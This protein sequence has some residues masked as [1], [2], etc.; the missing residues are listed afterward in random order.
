MSDYHTPSN[1][2]NLTD[3][4]LKEFFKKMIEI[5]LFEDEGVRLYKQG[6]VGGFYHSYKGQE[7][8]AVA[9]AFV[10]GQKTGDFLQTYRCHGLYLALNGSPQAGFAELLGKREGCSG[11][12]GGS[13][14]LSLPNMPLGEGIVCGHAALAA[15]MAHAK[16]HLGNKSPQVV[17]FLGDGAVAQGLIYEA[18]N[19]AKLSKA[20][21]IY[22]I[23][24]N[25][26][27]MG[28]AV[29]RAI[30]FHP[31]GKKLAQLYDLSSYYLKGCDLFHLID[32]FTD[33]LNDSRKT[34]MPIIVEVD[35]YRYQGH[36]ISDPGNYR[37]REEI[38]CYIKKN[39]CIAIIRKEMEQRKI[40]I[41]TC[42]KEVRETIRIALDK[43]ME[44]KD[45][46]EF[47]MKKGVLDEV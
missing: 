35:T 6:A 41:E 17:C 29:D 44:G 32:S 28:T 33:V 47:D 20:P 37:D 12:I 43:A 14:H 7:A 45:P 25:R 23:E 5:R 3:Q 11:G 36:S 21:A 8:I 24:N 19:I 38:E 1:K 2:R 34:S 10:F 31:L 42:E 15:G 18:L 4:E 46:D 40:D 39:D 16:N 13:M 27:G 30:S 9:S 22:V 26:Y